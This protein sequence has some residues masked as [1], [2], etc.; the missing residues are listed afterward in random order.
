[1]AAAQKGLDLRLMN[2]SVA[3]EGLE[4]KAPETARP[5][6][7]ALGHVNSQ[8]EPGRACCEVGEQREHM[9]APAPG[10][11]LRA[12]SHCTDEEAEA[13]RDDVTCPQTQSCPVAEWEPSPGGL[14][15]EPPAL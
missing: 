5:A 7:K 11:V 8:P 12:G 3:S 9:P 14:A 6:S 2:E 15:P 4:M 10:P 1:M 13:S